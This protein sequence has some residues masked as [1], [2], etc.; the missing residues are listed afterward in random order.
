MDTEQHFDF[1][2][3]WNNFKT[4]IPCILPKGSVLLHSF[5]MNSFWFNFHTNL[6]AYQGVKLE[7][8]PP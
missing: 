2:V 1:G 3:S 6:A 5:V 7:E 4:K 8:S